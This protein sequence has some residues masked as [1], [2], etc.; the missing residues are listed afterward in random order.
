MRRAAGRWVATLAEI[1]CETIKA[2]HGEHFPWQITLFYWSSA[3][4]LIPEIPFQA[5][6][7]SNIRLSNRLRCPQQRTCTRNQG[8][9]RVRAS[10]RSSIRGRSSLNTTS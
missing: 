9:E 10:N 4:G 2:A 6:P 8:A 1:G 5:S 7:P 3:A